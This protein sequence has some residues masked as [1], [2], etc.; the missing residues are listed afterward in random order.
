MK[1]SRI[2]VFF[3]LAAFVAIWIQWWASLDFPLTHPICGEGQAAK[4]CPSYN[5]FLFSAWQLAK[6]VD[7]WGV[8]ITA[9]ATVVVAGFTGTIYAINKSQLAHSHQVERAYF[10]GGGFPEFRNVTPASLAGETDASIR[11]ATGNFLIHINNQGKTPG[12]LLE[13]ALE[14]CDAASI[15]PQ[16]I[17]NRQRHRDWYGPGTQSRA[18]IRIPI[19]ANISNPVIYG[20]FYYRDIFSDQ[21]HSCGFIQNID[22]QE[23]NSGPI[24]PPSR[25]YVDWD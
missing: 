15:P 9:M 20:R 5:A 16:P 18:I 4:D 1:D 24:I 21:I 17:Y 3:S 23:I 8:L 22:L 10:S 25:A 19:P 14:F 7:Q 13:I 2:V 11:I 12:E 6:A